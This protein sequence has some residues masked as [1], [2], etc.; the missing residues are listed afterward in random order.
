MNIDKAISIK[1]L[2]EINVPYKEL[3]FFQGK[4]KSIEKSKFDDL[5]K[6]LI[7][8][9]LPLAFHIWIDSKGKKWLIDGHHRW[10]AF[11]ALES[12]GYFIP[13]IP[14]ILVNA[15]TK[16]EAAKIVLVAN[17]RYAKMT[18]E[19][20][21]DYMIDFELSVD[22]LDLLDIPELDMSTFNNST[23]DFESG[24]EDD[25]GKL[26]ELKPINCKCPSCGEEF[27]ARENL[28]KD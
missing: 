5:K 4:L 24:N 27:N 20:I 11:E 17:S 6:S 19:S 9:G 13:P 2:S 18:Q 3:N 22:D 10:L 28:I 7:K 15:K 1:C 23:P 8:S 14:C 21:S 25:Q 26:D 16:K 12:E